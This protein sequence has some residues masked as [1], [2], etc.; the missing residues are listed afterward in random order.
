[1]ADNAYEGYEW[2]QSLGQEFKPTIS[3]G[4]GSLFPRTHDTPSGIGAEFI[5][6]YIKYLGENYVDQVQ[7]CY[8]VTAEELVLTD[9]VCNTVK[10]TDKDGN[11]YTFTAKGGVVLA[12]GGFAGNVE[13]RV[14]YCQ[15]E[16]WPWARTWA[17]P[18]WR[19]IP[20]TAS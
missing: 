15:S 19:A 14:E 8:G 2:L 12:T 3:Q 4:P 20:A 7:F 18:A 9:G 11:A 10:G 16:K 1:M 13:M 17:A 6:T 5:N